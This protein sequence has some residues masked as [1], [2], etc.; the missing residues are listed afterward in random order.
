MKNNNNQ[1]QQLFEEIKYL[2]DCLDVSFNTIM[3]L[4]EETQRLKDEIA[5]LKGQKPRPKIPPSTL[6]GAKSKD[7]QKSNHFLRHHLKILI[8]YKTENEFV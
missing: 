2:K 1:I 3:S 7:K 8:P 4:K 6:E 5:V